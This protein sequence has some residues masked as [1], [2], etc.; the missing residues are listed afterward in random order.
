MAAIH[1]TMEALPAGWAI[2]KNTMP[3]FDEACLTPI[4]PT[5]SRRSPSRIVLISAGEGARRSLGILTINSCGFPAS[6][7]R[8][9]RHASTC[10]YHGDRLDLENTQEPNVRQHQ[11]GA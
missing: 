1:E 7:D 9:M 5:G 8:E 2:D 11:T 4:W 6:N 10:D 3:H